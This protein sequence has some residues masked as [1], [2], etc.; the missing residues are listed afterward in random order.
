MALP[1]TVKV[2]KINQEAEDIRSFELVD[3]EGRLLPM[4]TAGSHI[5]VELPN[6]LMRQY[7]ISN[8][9]RDVDRYVIAVLREV[10]GRGRFRQHA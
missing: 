1:L 9:P 2:D 3:P 8:D 7:S 4:F 6:G 10:E 5:D